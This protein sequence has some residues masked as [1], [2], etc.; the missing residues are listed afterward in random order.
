MPGLGVY[1]GLIARRHIHP[2]ALFRVTG[3]PQLSDPQVRITG[4][5]IS[6][7]PTEADIIAGGKTIILT[8]DSG[9]TWLAAGANFNGTRQA[10]IDGLSGTGVSVIRAAMAVTDVARTS[11]QIVTITLP[12]VPLFNATGSVQVSWTMP[13][14]ITL[15][16]AEFH[17]RNFGSIS[18]VAPSVTAVLTGT[19]ITGGVTEAQ[20]VTGGETLIIT[21]TGANWVAAGAAS[22]DTV[23]AAITAGL[24]ANENEANGWNV[25]IKVA[26]GMPLANVVRTSNSV[27]T[28]TS[29]A[30]ASYSVTANE[31][32]TATIPAAAIEA[33]DAAVVATPTIVVTAS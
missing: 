33:A 4:T 3:I 16:T 8:L 20:L 27:V 9:Y 30:A 21:L 29:A 23:R 6:A 17:A 13:L 19:M 2:R 7:P 11:A 5:F 15:P 12:A 31:N 28:I 22:F 32:I 1:K 18:N 24:T 14:A 25:R 26:A 10:I